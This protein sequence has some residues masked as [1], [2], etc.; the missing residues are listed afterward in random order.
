[1]RRLFHQPLLLLIVLWT[2]PSIAAPF[3]ESFLSAMAA[4][5]ASVAVVSRDDRRQ[6]LASI[7]AV[8]TS[9]RDHPFYP[10]GIEDDLNAL[11]LTP[12]GREDVLPFLLRWPVSRTLKTQA[13]EAFELR[14]FFDLPKSSFDAPATWEQIAREASWVEK[15]LRPLRDPVF[16]SVIEPFVRELVEAEVQLAAASTPGAPT[17][18]EAAAFKERVEISSGYLD[19]FFYWKLRPSRRSLR[20]PPPFEAAAGTT[21][22]RASQV[23]ARLPEL[24]RGWAQR[25]LEGMTFYEAGLLLKT[26]FLLAVAPRK[27]GR[28]D[29]VVD[30]PGARKA[31]GQTGPVKRCRS[32]FKA[33][34]KI[35]GV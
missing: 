7:D 15:F 24:G 32:F 17:G 6:F 19:A 33:S 28:E 23:N 8:M 27:K 3:P 30:L 26:K 11:L 5:G 22:D 1:M 12:D 2:P 13:L 4:Y 10:T 29:E 20:A 16:L 18:S 31:D 21:S 35:E 25:L 14:Y 9:G 34:N